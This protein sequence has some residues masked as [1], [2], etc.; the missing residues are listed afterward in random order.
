MSASTPVQ[1]PEVQEAPPPEVQGGPWALERCFHLVNGLAGDD[2]TWVL[3][4][5]RSV[6][7]AIDRL[8]G[9]DLKCLAGICIVYSDSQEGYFVI[10]R[11]DKQSEA[12]GSFLRIQPGIAARLAATKTYVS[13]NMTVLPVVVK[14]YRLLEF[15]AQ[16]LSLCI[17]TW[18]VNP[19]VLAVLFVA[20]WYYP[21]VWT[22]GR[23]S[24]P[25][26]YP[27]YNFCVD[28]FSFLNLHPHPIHPWRPY[29]VAFIRVCILV[30]IVPL[31]VPGVSPLPE[32]LRDFLS[33]K[34]ALEQIQ[35]LERHTA[36]HGGVSVYAEELWEILALLIAGMSIAWLIVVIPMLCLHKCVAYVG[37]ARAELEAIQRLALEL[38]FISQTTGSEPERCR[39]AL[40]SVRERHPGL[41]LTSAGST[42]GPAWAVLVHLAVDAFNLISFLQAGD[43]VRGGLLALTIFITAC[44][45]NN[46]SSGGL[47]SIVHE[48][49]H[50]WK[51]GMFTD[52][53]LAYVKADKGI[54]AIP[55]LII[56]ISGLPFKATNVLSTVGGLGSIIINVALVVPFIYEQFDL[57][58]EVEGV[59]D[60]DDE[61]A[62][63]FVS[64]EAAS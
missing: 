48:T 15:S 35:W 32:G 51:R 28:D 18:L 49:M 30:A 22:T 9:G 34:K 16:V 42:I 26:G 4:G 14:L 38:E 29:R 36:K 54:Q 11:D 55:S 64:A 12:L 62:E 31:L 17:M 24:R 50:S 63:Q 46:V 3:E 19:A 6:N 57:G 20:L 43:M 21:A 2:A 10:F 1:P 56:I 53:Y 61:D 39:Q 40:E 47:K 59:E 27:I 25:L 7:A 41:R 13:E 23:F 33:H 44:Y 8:N 60:S 37:D 45:A 52:D 5:V 58:T